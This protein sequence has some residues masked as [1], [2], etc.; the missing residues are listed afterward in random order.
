MQRI[1]L[2]DNR[3]RIEGLYGFESHGRFRRYTDEIIAAYPRLQDADRKCVGV[4]LRFR[5]DSGRIGIELRLSNQ[6]VDRGMSFYQANAAYAFVGDYS[7]A[8][9]AALVSADEPYQDETI[10]AEFGNTGMNDVTVFFP[11]NPTV[12][13]VCVFLEDG[14]SL[15]PPTPHRLK[16][17]FVFYGSSITQ[18]GHTSSFAAYPSLLSRFFDADIYNF[19]ASGNAM[20]EPELAEYLGRIPKSLFFCEYDHNAPT[21][22]HLQ[23]THEA[24]FCR[25]RAFDPL[26]PVILTSRPADDTVETAERAAIIR[27]TYEHARQR[28]DRNVYFADGRTLFGDADPALCTTDR[29]HPND[30]GH[31]QIAETLKGLILDAGILGATESV[32][33]L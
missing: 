13:D 14:A 18:Q 33:A 1:G 30:L 22:S 28:G 29:T 21:V 9:Y 7:A 11:Q 26:T 32:R 12:E 10:R 25:F 6:Y 3:I 27:E 8:T 20:G 31:Y 4:R 5:T 15:E 24:F 2:S 16:L 23:K 19:G 17:P